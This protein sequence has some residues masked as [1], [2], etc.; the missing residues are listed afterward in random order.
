ML[1]RLQTTTA[2]VIVPSCRV[3]VVD[4]DGEVADSLVTFLRY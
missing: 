2:P 1:F 3:L 4:E